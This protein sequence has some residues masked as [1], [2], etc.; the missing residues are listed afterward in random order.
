MHFYV[1]IKQYIDVDDAIVIF[2]IYALLRTP[3]FLFDALRDVQNFFDRLFRFNLNHGIEKIVFRLK[4]NG[5]VSMEG[6][7]IVTFSKRCLIRKM[8]RSILS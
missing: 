3:H 5:A 6:A 8:A 7:T 2:A 4:T 1:I